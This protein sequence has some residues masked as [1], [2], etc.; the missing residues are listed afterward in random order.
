MPKFY[1]VKPEFGQF[2]ISISIPDKRYKI[3]FRRETIQLIGYELLT[4]K[5]YKLII[6][7]HR[8]KG[9]FF[10]ELDLN[11]KQ[12]YWSFGCMF[13]V[14]SPHDSEMI[15]TAKKVHKRMIKEAAELY[16][17]YRMKRSECSPS[18]ISIMT[19]E[20]LSVDSLSEVINYYKTEGEKL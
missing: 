4:E 5:I 10:L 8:H 20:L 14:G 17:N 1:Q 12:V 19:L 11:D 3:G 6:S 15:D 13:K 7:Q 16:K 2:R 18:W 9:D